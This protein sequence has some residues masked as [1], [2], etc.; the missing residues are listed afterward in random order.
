MLVLLESGT[1]SCFCKSCVNV[2][3]IP[4]VLSSKASGKVKMFVC[5]I[6][7]CASCS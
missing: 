7:C 2:L 1:S 4:S 6:V 3:K 5:G